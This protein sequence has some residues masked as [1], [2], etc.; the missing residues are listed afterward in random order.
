MLGGRDKRGKV[1]ISSEEFVKVTS[2]L[3][4]TG[5]LSDAKIVLSDGSSFDV[6]KTLLAAG[7]LF[8]RR[9]FILEKSPEYKIHNVCKESFEQILNWMYKHSIKLN[10]ENIA[11]VLKDAHYLDCPEVI[12]ECSEFMIREMSP[13]NAIGF[14]QY[15]RI[16]NILDLQKKCFRFITS[17]FLLVTKE[18]EFLQLTVDDLTTIIK[19][20]DLNAEEVDVFYRILAWIEHKK[21]ERMDHLVLCSS[22]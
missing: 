12:E 10:Y 4:Q 1:Y 22:P 13:L 16:Y 20:D 3:R 2:K 18:E 7:S 14:E 8:F 21:I 9:L 6:H 5:H 17:N 11:D 15:C 19:S